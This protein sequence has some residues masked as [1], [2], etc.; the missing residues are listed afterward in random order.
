MPVPTQAQIDESLR[1]PRNNPDNWKQGASLF[2]QFGYKFKEN[3]GIIGTGDTDKFTDFDKVSTSETFVPTDDDY[4]VFNPQDPQHEMINDWDQ[5]AIF[6]YGVQ[7]RYYKLK[8]QGEQ[9]YYH[10]LYRENPSREY[11]GATLER[12]SKFAFL[13]EVSP[14]VVWGLYEP[15]ELSQDLTKHSMD[16]KRTAIIQFS[17]VYIQGILGRDPVIGDVIIPWDIPEQLFEVMTIEPAE[18]TLYVPRRWSLSCN[19]LQVSQ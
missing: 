19:L 4:R 14:T 3:R 7:M 1:Q 10:E 11:E 2:E 5:D 12:D 13:T 15:G 16:T 8:P 18:K 6:A 17:R 9:K